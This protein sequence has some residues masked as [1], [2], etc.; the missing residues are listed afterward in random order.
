MMPVTQPAPSGETGALHP[1][2]DDDKIAL[3]IERI[4]GDPMGLDDRVMAVENERDADGEDN[5]RCC[6][7]G[8]RAAQLSAHEWV[9]LLSSFG[10]ARHGWA[11]PTTG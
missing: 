3:V 5:A 11:D 1:A 4:H 10:G 7:G 2:L 8:Q 6:D 9:H